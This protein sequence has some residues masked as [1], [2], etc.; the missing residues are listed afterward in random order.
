VGKARTGAQ[1]PVEG[2]VLRQFVDPAERGDDRLAW[3]AV[4]ALVLDDL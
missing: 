1:Q 4:D 3:L 2:A